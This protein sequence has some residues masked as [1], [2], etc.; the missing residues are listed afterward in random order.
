MQTN[1]LPAPPMVSE[2]ASGPSL[3]D[4]RASVISSVCSASTR[5]A[6]WVEL[7]TGGPV[8]HGIGHIS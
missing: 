7:R 5:T 2:V 4:S 3:N 1:W 8:C 6:S